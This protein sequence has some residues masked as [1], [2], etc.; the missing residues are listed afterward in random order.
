MSTPE[1]DLLT[2]IFSSI[3]PDAGGPEKIAAASAM[4]TL[5][6]GFNESVT[7]SDSEKDAAHKV[8]PEFLEQQ[9]KMKAKSEKSDEDESDEDES[10]DASEK[11]AASS[12][13]SPDAFLQALHIYNAP[14]KAAADKRAAANYLRTHE[15]MAK[16]ASA[17]AET[18]VF[19]GRV[20]GAAFVDELEK[21]GSALAEG[22]AFWDYCTNNPLY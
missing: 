14:V 18:E 2:R 13:T 12:K 4:E 10:E 1:T 9:K 6:R 19:G 16:I 17:Q 8:P 21:I 7:D 3:P 22:Q 20:A 5:I 15:T 11:E